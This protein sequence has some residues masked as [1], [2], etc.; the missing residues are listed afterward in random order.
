MTSKTTLTLQ[1]VV[2]CT[3]KKLKMFG[4]TINFTDNKA[5]Y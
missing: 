2:F 4:T 1:Y 5:D 3:Y